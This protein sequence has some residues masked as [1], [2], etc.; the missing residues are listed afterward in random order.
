VPLYTLGDSAQDQD[1]YSSFGWIESTDDLLAS[2]VVLGVSNT[3]LIFD[4][5]TFP[6][7]DAKLRLRITNGPA[8]IGWMQIRW[9]PEA[10]PANYG[11]GA[12]APDSRGEALIAELLYAPGLIGTTVEFQLGATGNPANAAAVAFVYAIFKALTAGSWRRVALTVKFLNGEA[13]PL[14]I[15]SSDKVGGIAPVLVT[16]EIPPE[17]DSVS[18][19][20]KKLRAILKSRLNTHPDVQALPMTFSQL[21]GRP[22]EALAAAGFAGYIATHPEAA[23]DRTGEVR[24]LEVMVLIVAGAVDAETNADQLDD[25]QAAVEEAIMADVTMGGLVEDMRFVGSVYA[26]DSTGQRHYGTRA[27]TYAAPFIREGY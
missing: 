18:Q 27:I 2:Q 10:Y 26:I 6:V 25:A 21:P 3:G 1:G 4:T 9:V 15:D 13:T 19:L 23:I 7:T 20:A 14:T 11:A 8:G 12:L 24:E 16:E 5:T 22:I 17:I